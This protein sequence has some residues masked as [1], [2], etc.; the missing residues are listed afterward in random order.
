MKK[1]LNSQWFCSL[2]TTKLYTFVLYRPCIFTLVSPPTVLLTYHKEQQQ[3]TSHKKGFWTR[4]RDGT[5]N[6]QLT[7]WEWH[8]S[9]FTPSILLTMH[10][11][12]LSTCTLGYSRNEWII[13]HQKDTTA[14][15]TALCIQDNSDI[16]YAQYHPQYNSL[17]MHV[18][19]CTTHP[20]LPTPL[21]STILLYS[22]QT[23][24]I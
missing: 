4:C 12:K 23:H 15:P 2:Q 8:H 18:N 9:T 10:T 3:R 5:L 19:I 16:C 14:H 21:P 20:A 22:Q 1:N 24:G 13:A 7:T 17:S 6:N 11:T